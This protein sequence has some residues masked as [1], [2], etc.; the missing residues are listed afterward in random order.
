MKRRQFLRTSAAASAAIALMPAMA[1][2]AAERK[3]GLILYTV[4]GEMNKDPLGTLDKVAEI[5]YNWIELASYSDGKFYNM[6]PS[7]LKDEIEQRGMSLI[8]SHNGLNPNN[9]DE[10]VDAAAEAGLIYLIMPSLGGVYTK[11]LDG[12]KKA[13]DF[14]NEAG[15]K[16][17]KAGMKLG[18][19]NHDMEFRPI[20]DQ[21]PYDIL[22]EN[23]DPDLVTFEL[24]LAWIKKGNQS[25]IEY[26]NKYPGRFEIWHVK[27]LSA[28]LQ[29]ATLGEGSVDFGPIFK[30]E[31]LSGMKYF[32]VEQD[33]SRTRTPLENIRIS[34]DFLFSEVF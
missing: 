14:M 2:T 10:V 24:D 33:S 32:F 13:A 29:D 21:I 26:F 23:T 28:E 31:K 30:N 9:V 15:A 22:V 8:S 25:S 12:F 34:R 3:T 11:S 7:T 16:C 19:H 17:K 18:F 6:K 4:R 5:G 20:D 1:C 27:D